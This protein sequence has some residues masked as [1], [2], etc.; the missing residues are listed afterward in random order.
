MRDEDWDR[1]VDALNERGVTYLT[2]G[3]GLPSGM[4]DDELIRA[5][6]ESDDARLRLV[7]IPLMLSRPEL[8]ANVPPLIEHLAPARA[9]DLKQRYTAAVCLQRFWRTRL[10]ETIGET[11]P[12]PDWFSA[13]FGLASC[14]ELFGRLTLYRLAEQL[15]SQNKGSDYWGAFSKTFEDFIRQREV[16]QP[17]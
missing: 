5:L 3:R 14:D 8:S 7:I 17:A 12:L 11:S 13:E 10:A 1:I 9:L 4:S 15:S 6:V 2:G 16:E